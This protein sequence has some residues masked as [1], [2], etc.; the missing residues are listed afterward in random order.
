[1]ICQSKISVKILDTQPENEKTDIKW[2]NP[3][4]V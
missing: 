3:M 4:P 1:M 2:F